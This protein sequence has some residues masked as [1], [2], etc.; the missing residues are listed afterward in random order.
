MCG[1]SRLLDE[2]FTCASFCKRR[3][4]FVKVCNCP[5][6]RSN[7]N[8]HTI[9]DKIDRKLIFYVSCVDAKSVLLLLIVDRT[10]K[11][12]YRPSTCHPNACTSSC[13]SRRSLSSRN[14][15]RIPSTRPICGCTAGRG[16]PADGALVSLRTRQSHSADVHASRCTYRRATFRPASSNAG[17]SV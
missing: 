7:A 16:Y 4:T 17:C 12:I 2:S 1:S 10:S 8:R 9:T 14:T 6:F 5:P 11:C 13:R 15:S 3:I